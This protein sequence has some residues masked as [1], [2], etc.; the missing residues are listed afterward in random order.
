MDELSQHLK[1]LRKEKSVSL[2]QASRDIGIS[3]TYL[4]SLEKGFDP[5]TNKERKPTFDVLKKLSN[6]YKVNYID[7]LQKSGYIEEAEKEGL[8]KSAEEYRKY[9]KRNKLEDIADLNERSFIFD[10]IIDSAYINTDFIYE[11]ETLNQDEKIFIAD[12]LRIILRND[13]PVEYN[14]K[15][16]VLN[17][18]ETILK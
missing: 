7:L 11:G 6:Y 18:I 1:K 10:D 13:I 15:K 9:R 17:L 16:K 2:R 12:V 3:H 4:D 8:M 14:E 5:R